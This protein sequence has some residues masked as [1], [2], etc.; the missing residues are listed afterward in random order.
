MLKGE[1]DKDI[2]TADL[3]IDEQTVD[4]LTTSV[5][6]QTEIVEKKAVKTQVNIVRKIS[7]KI[8]SL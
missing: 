1:K 8:K 6:C 4:D 3:E 7:T 2:P 5:C